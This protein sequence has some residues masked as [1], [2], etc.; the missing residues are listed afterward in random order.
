MGV[1]ALFRGVT[2]DVEGLVAEV[3]VVDHAVGVVAVLPYLAGEILAYGEKNPPLTS[4]AQ[5]S[6]AMSGAGVSRMWTWSGMT[7]KA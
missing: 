4:W 5:R 6:I 7:T 2:E 1:E 3:F